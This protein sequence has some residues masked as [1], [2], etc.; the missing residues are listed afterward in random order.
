LSGWT[1]A[2]TMLH[3]IPDAAIPIGTAAERLGVTTDAIRKRIRRGTLAAHKRG[4]VWYVV[5]PAVPDAPDADPDSDPDANPDGEISHL[6]TLLA[7]VRQQ[8][9]GYAAQLSTKDRQIEELHVLLQRALEQR[10]AL[11]LPPAEQPQPASPEP[12]PPRWWRRLFRGP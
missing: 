7:E 11:V 5:L 8:R 2:K 3:T 12:A 10:P 6:R 4:D 9:D 1:E